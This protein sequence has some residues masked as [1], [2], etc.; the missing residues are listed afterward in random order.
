[1]TRVPVRVHRRSRVRLQL[2][3]NCLNHT[4]DE[5][6]H[7]RYS[8]GTALHLY[9]QDIPRYHYHCH[10]LYT[11][12]L[13]WM[14]AITPPTTRWHGPP[15]PPGRVA[16]RREEASSAGWRFLPPCP[17]PRC[18]PLLFSSFFTLLFFTPVLLLPPV[19]LEPLISTM[20]FINKKQ[21]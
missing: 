15:T 20:K 4:Q 18:F 19:C 1:M 13:K 5:Q 9:A 8:G 11:T 7:C 2:C 17:F 16:S 3:A 14:T 12:L 21:S 6:Q 10:V